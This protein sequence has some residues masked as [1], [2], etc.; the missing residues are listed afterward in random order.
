MY[1]E[2]ET[3]KKIGIQ[4]FAEPGGSGA[5]DQ[6]A[7][8]DNN[9]Q[10]G[11]DGQSG[12]AGTP[13]N[14]PAGKTFTQDD[15]NAM[16]ANEKRTARMA[17]LKELGY[18]VKDGDYKKVISTVKGILD[19]GKTQQ[20]LD[21]EARTKAEGDLASEQAKNSQLQAQLEV[22]KAGV[23]PDYVDDAIAMLM[24]RVTQNKPL[25]KLLEEYKTKYPAWFGETTGSTGTGSATNP[26]RGKGGEVGTMGKRLAQVNA[27]PAKSN[28]FKN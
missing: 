1:E 7:E 8:G 23:K 14:P 24:P 11:T 25:T 27:A 5:G 15:V 9:P 22:M 3:H 21:Q 10:P 13:A 2:A 12:A 17:L 6:G 28:F 4:F 18:E 16:M 19:Q 20:Q 26:P